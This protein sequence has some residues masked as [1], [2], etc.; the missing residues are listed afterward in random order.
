MPAKVPTADELYDSSVS[1][2]AGAMSAHASGSHPRLAVD[3]VTALEHLMKACLIR[4]SPV[5]LVDLG[6]D[7]NWGSLR[8]LAGLPDPSVGFLRTIGV[9]EALKRTDTFFTSSVSRVELKLLFDLRNGV[10]HTGF[11]EAVEER[12]LV[13]FVKQA[14]ACLSD[15]GKDRVAFWGGQ[16]N[17]VDALITDSTDKALHRVQIKLAAAK[18]RFIDKFAEL[19]PELVAAVRLVSPGDT[20]LEE[21]HE[22][23]SCQSIGLGTGVHHVEDEY[24]VDNEGVIQGGSRVVF[25]PESFT[26]GV[27]GL[28]LTSADE[29][30]LAGI[31]PE[32]ES[33]LVPQDLLDYG[34]DL[35]EAD[36][37]TYMEDDDHY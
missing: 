8:V 18:A 24:E 37:H 34:D 1:F 16:L 11:D 9:Q 15:L 28:R 23:P 4:R 36:Y 26:C 13:A 19:S 3:A 27:C 35:G 30:R 14:D 7:G 33:S 21:Q 12:L 29:I 5:L 32:W 17:V 25:W 20:D 22:C 10:V 6:R 31:N 2:A